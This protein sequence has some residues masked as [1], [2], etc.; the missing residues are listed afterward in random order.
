MGR[1]RMNAHKQKYLFI[2]HNRL[3][4]HINGYK[5]DISSCH[6]QKF[7]TNMLPQVTRH[8]KL[9]HTLL[10]GYYIVFWCSQKVLKLLRQQK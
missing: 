5:I 4:F 6:M 7:Q 1:T 9:T 3:N 2:F 8:L 10:C